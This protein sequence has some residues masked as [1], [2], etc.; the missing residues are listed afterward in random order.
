MPK[1]GESVQAAVSNS[2]IAGNTGAI[3]VNSASAQE[4]DSLPGIGPVTAEKI[5][6]G[7]SY[8]SINDLLE[9]KVVS[10]KVFNQIKDKIT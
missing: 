7:R 2:G 3:N 10:E 8:T 6:S 4:L 9:K 5:I 1:F